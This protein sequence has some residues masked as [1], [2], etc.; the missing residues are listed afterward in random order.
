MGSL[1]KISSKFNIQSQSRSKILLLLIDNIDIWRSILAFL[2]HFNV[3][4]HSI[5]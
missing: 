1:T 5:P 2:N 4:N 3:P